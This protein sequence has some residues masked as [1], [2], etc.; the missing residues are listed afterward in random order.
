MERQSPVIGIT[1][2][3]RSAGGAFTLPATYVEAV[4]RAGGA[5]VLLP[6]QPQPASLSLIAALDGIMFTGGGDISPDCYSGVQHPT[7]YGVDDSRDTFEL[8]LARYLLT[9]QIPTL[10]ICRGMQMLAV[11][12]GAELLPHLPEIYGEQVMHRLDQPH[13]PIPHPVQT[14]PESRLALLLDAA[15]FEIVSWHHQAIKALPDGWQ[16]AAT[17]ADGLI[18]AMEYQSHPWMFAVQWHPEL[19]PDAPVQQRLFEAFVA[20]CEL[21]LETRI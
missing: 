6:P 11:A 1:T 19:S 10:G 17:A 21:K 16:L 3:S 7:V 2:Y 12:S 5:A 9:S 15:E 4:Q 8:E 14:V 20:A 18:E 13:R